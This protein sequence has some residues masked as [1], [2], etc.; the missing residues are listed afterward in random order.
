[1]L[2]TLDHLISIW[3]SASMRKH[4]DSTHCVLRRVIIYF[5]AHQRWDVYNYRVCP[6]HHWV[7]HPLDNSSPTQ[8]SRYHHSATAMSTLCRLRPG[9]SPLS[10]AGS[11]WLGQ[12]T[13]SSKTDPGQASAFRPWSCPTGMLWW[14][15]RGRVS[16]ILQKGS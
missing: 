12:I 8:S 4:L 11:L 2:Y 5:T 14:A 16:M 15:L 13:Q 7:S 6:G 1:M 3:M 9:H 10:W